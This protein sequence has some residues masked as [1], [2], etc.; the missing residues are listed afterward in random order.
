[1]NPAPR[2]CWR[3]VE[4]KKTDGVWMTRREKTQRAPKKKWQIAILK[5]VIEK[6]DWCAQ[7]IHADKSSIYR[8][9]PRCH[10]E[11]LKK[12]LWVQ[13]EE[14]VNLKLCVA[15]VEAEEKYYSQP[16]RSPCE[17]FRNNTLQLKT[18]PSATV[19]EILAWLAHS[20]SIKQN[21]WNCIYFHNKSG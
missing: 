11:S 19:A 9:S 7:Y 8:G 3:F 20:S 10:V 4:E 5:S 16:H 18:S 1:M 6:N 14:H 2:V 21:D 15:D 13:R 17:S 12:T